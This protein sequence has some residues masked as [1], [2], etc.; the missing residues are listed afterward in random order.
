MVQSIM[1]ATFLFIY[2][3]FFF[4]KSIVTFFLSVL[5]VN[6]FFG[7]KFFMVLDNNLLKVK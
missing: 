3:F 7:A 6:F 5:K 4:G 1:C 2:I